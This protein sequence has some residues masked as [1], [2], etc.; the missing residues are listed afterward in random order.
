[1]PPSKVQD[2]LPLFR[3]QPTP[4]VVRG[5]RDPDRTGTGK[6]TS[7]AHARILAQASIVVLVV[8]VPAVTVVGLVFV[9]AR[10]R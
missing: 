3:R 4:D 10:G 5:Q 8:P 6:Q 9:L 7:L 1:M 2:L